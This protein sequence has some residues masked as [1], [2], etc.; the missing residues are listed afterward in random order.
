MLDFHLL[1]RKV[2]SWDRLWPIIDHYLLIANDKGRSGRQ[3]AN[4][5]SLAEDV[6][7]QD[8]VLIMFGSY[9]ESQ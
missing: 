5:V 7:G 8:V 3:M 9:N 2:L 6:Q 4:W 1:P